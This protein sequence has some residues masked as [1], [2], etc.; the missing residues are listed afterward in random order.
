MLDPVM[1]PWD[2]APFLPILREAGGTFTDWTGKAT[3]YGGN[4]IA[5]NGRLLEETLRLLR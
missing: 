4:G 1:Q 3:I 2:C 5:S